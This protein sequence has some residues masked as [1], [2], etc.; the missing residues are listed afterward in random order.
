MSLKYYSK[1]LSIGLLAFS[2]FT[3]AQS[4][5]DISI[6]LILDASG[7][8]QAKLKS[9]ERRI[10][11]A[12]AAVGSFARSTADETRLSLWA[13]G[14]QSHRSKK[15]CADIQQL[16][17][18][19]PLG[20]NRAD[21]IAKADALKAQGY[22]PISDILEQAANDLKSE[23][24]AQ[25][26]AVVL[27]SDGKET[28]EGDPCAV[29]KALAE[30]DANLV[31]HTIGFAVDVAAR[32]ELQCI[33]RQGRGKYFEAADVDKLSESLSKATKAA[34]V[35][36]PEPIKVEKKKPGTLELAN[37]SASNHDVF[38]ST[39]NEQV[40]NL[41]PVSPT[42]SLPAGIYKVKFGNA[43]WKGIEI[44]DGEKTTIDTAIVTVPYASFKGNKIL[45]WETDEEIGKLSSQRK[46]MNLMPS[47]FKVMFGSMAY[48]ISLQPGSR[49]SIDAGAVKFKGLPV[50]YRSIYN[51]AGE[52]VMSVSNSG[53]TATLLPGEYE[54]E[55][56]DKR[57]GF[58]IKVN[59]TVEVELD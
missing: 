46:S 36:A 59:E 21:L 12:K 40:G 5:E 18:Y 20:D 42:I 55:H 50:N 25:S 39:T 30:A 34:A 33:A 14:H 47:T 16:T 51:D 22:T 32:Y 19:Q 53:S 45:D 35:K 7:S 27:V 15:N 10:N 37:T 44:V 11:A 29:A 4:S 1:V 28:C 9:G 31:I 8:M 43:Y 54:L 52:E 2:L 48:E 26:R 17:K 23:S 38:L 3:P 24:S 49:T 58:T 56:N 6:A 41:G 57:Y 13:Y